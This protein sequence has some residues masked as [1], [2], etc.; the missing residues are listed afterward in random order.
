MRVLVVTAMYPTKDKPASGT[1]VKDQV[2]SLKKAGLDVD[3]FVFDGGNWKKYVEAGRKIN[4]IL[5]HQTYDI[6][7]AHY[8]L[9]GLPARMQTAC[10]LVIT[11]HGSDLLGGVDSRHHYTLKGSA[12]ASINKLAGL[13]A[14]KCIVVADRLKPKLWFRTTTTI[15]MGVD[16]ATFKPMPAQHAREQL[17]L[18]NQKQRVL[19]VAH[20]KNNIKRFDVAQAAVDLLQNN[21]LQVELL[22]VYNVPHQQV[23]VYMNASDVLV[24]TSMH[25]ASPCVVKEAMACNLPVVSVDVGDVA[26]RIKNIEGCYICERTPE[27]VAAKLKKVLKSTVRPDTR[28]QITELSLEN[29]AQR[30][31][32]VYKE[33]LGPSSLL[34]RS[35][36]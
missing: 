10:P 6:V 11:F 33:A 27:D 29:T 2:E 24:L 5:R 13:L 12:L 20:P 32:A 16:L 21:G 30:V 15:P 36:L 17:G 3:V 19:F 1:F 4:A 8:G 26:E 23:P 28:S 25:E 7:H 9:T 35:S 18:D 14:T 34:T 22:P 31:I